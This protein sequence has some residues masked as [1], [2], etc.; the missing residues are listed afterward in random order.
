[1][2]YVNIL[3]HNES[4]K[5]LVFVSIW[6]W[7][8]KGRVLLIYLIIYLTSLIFLGHSLALA[9]FYLQYSHMTDMLRESDSCDI[10]TGS[11]IVFSSYL[12]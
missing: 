8:G 3:L 11:L 2:M 10:I 4:K 9:Q 1:M 5:I 12:F 7:C 6:V